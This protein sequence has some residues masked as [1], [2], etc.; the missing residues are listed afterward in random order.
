MGEPLKSFFDKSLVREI[1]RELR[2]AYPPLDEDAF[3]RDAVRG[4]RTMELT[5]RG[6]TSP[7]SC[8]D[9]YPTTFHAP[10]TSSFLPSGQN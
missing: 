8:A 1:A 2:G 3:V 10:S 7:T 5:A 6:R 4:L 9:T